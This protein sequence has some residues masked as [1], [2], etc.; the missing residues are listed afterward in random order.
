MKQ[1]SGMKGRVE[2]SRGMEML[3]AEAL[4]NIKPTDPLR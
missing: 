3:I 2:R 4:D 1:E